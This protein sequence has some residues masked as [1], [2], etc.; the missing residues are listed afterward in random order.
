MAEK[1]HSKRRPDPR[2]PE[3][4]PVIWRVVAPGASTYGH[5]WVFLESE[6]E[7]NARKEF[8]GLRRCGWPVRLERVSCGDL[9]AQPHMSLDRLHT[10]N[11]TRGSRRPPTRGAWRRAQP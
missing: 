6:D 1:Q 9:P 10:S 7:R 5:D 11:N 2:R 4:W 8:G 3:T